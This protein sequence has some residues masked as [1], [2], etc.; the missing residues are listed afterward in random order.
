MEGGYQQE[1]QD[2]D[3]EENA[4]GQPNNPHEHASDVW[5][6]DA[7]W[8]PTRFAGVTANQA[9]QHAAVPRKLDRDRL[10]ELVAATAAEMAGRVVAFTALTAD[11]VAWLAPGRVLERPRAR[12]RPRDRRRHG[13]GPPG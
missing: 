10:I 1:C 11:Q 6:A 9:I 3:H 13:G 8:A 5:R 2:A 12:S 7:A 4:D